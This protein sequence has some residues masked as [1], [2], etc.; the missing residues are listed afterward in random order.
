MLPVTRVTP[1]PP[2]HPPVTGPEERSVLSVF[3]VT[4]EQTRQVRF[5]A[6]RDGDGGRAAADAREAVLAPG[7]VHRLRRHC[8]AVSPC[9]QPPTPPLSCTSEKY[10][11]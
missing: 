7:E 2:P 10:I 3:P 6:R 9:S 8:C 5:H 1:H 11:I 4:H